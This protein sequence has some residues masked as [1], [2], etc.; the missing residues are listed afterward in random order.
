MS[1]SIEDLNKCSKCGN[2]SMKSNFNKDK[3]TKEGLHQQCKSSR[4]QKQK[5]YQSNNGEKKER[6]SEKQKKNRR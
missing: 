3:S 1:S 4:N 5:E 6:T 2:I